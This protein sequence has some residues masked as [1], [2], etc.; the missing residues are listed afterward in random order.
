MSEQVDKDCLKG[1]VY[2]NCE[3]SHKGHLVAIEWYRW[4]HEKPMDRDELYV[5]AQ[6]DPEVGFWRRLWSG[7]CYIVRGR[8]CRYG[9]W[10][11]TIVGR[12]DAI[13]LKEMLGDY[14]DALEAG[15]E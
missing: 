10:G 2:L 4:K 3:C 11:C 14:V 8:V 13:A 15:D 12:D 5:Q 6:M 7:L 1:R 9:A